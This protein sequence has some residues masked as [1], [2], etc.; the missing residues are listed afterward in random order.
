VKVIIWARGM[1]TAPAIQF[2][3]NVTDKEEQG[4]TS[5]Y[6]YFTGS[7]NK[8]SGPHILQFSNTMVVGLLCECLVSLKVVDMRLT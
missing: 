4:E 7:S 6:S 8:V 2:A 5:V 3:A 1:S